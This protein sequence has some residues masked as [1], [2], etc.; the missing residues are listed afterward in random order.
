MLRLTTSININSRHRKYEFGTQ[1]VILAYT[2]P[3]ILYLGPEITGFWRL[4]CRRIRS[5]YIYACGALGRQ[6]EA[7]FRKLEL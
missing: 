4:Q 7:F 5:A 6:M 2:V 1:S 3:E